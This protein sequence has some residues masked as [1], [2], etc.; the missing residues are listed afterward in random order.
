MG[1]V[2]L[3]AKDQLKIDILSKLQNHQISK[4]QAQL[5]LGVSDRTLRRLLKKYKDTGV[6]SVLHAN[7]F[8]SPKNKISM[9]LKIKV[10]Q[11]VVEKYFDFNM[12]HLNEKLKSEGLN[13]KRET[14][15]KWCHEINYVKKAKRRRGKSRSYRQR[16]ERPGI[17]L[18]MDGS[19]HKWYGDQ[20]SCL[21]AVIDDANNEIVYAEFCEYETTQNCFKA[22]RHI[23]ESKGLF[24]ALYVDQA[25]LYGGMKR[26]GF[27]QVKRACEELGIQVIYAH[28]PQAK[29]R[30]ERLFSTLQDRLIPEMR[31]SKIRTQADANDYL[32]NNFIPNQYNDRFLLISA[33]P[34]P[35]YEKV[36]DLINLDQVLCHKEFRLIGNDQTVSFENEKQYIDF[37]FKYS[38]SGYKLEIRTL[39]NGKQE[40]YVGKTKVKL[41]KIEKLKKA[42]A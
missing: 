12:T 39:T 16:M 26:N 5:I 20:E 24:K 1:D 7:R 40:Y 15:R 21:I 6:Y 33:D 14:L 30:I 8:R 35:A 9:D 25:G 4:D 23:A 32:K 10:Q 38:V 18:Q 3:K 22:I 17:L 13:I 11:L 37:Q 36:H 34:R 2:L 41:L 27:S 19:Y 29:G 31:L 28:S 42:V